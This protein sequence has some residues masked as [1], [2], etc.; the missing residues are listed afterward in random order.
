VEIALT[1]EEKSMLA[2]SVKSVQAV[3]DLC[4]KR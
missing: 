1:E 4:N 2:K 3:V